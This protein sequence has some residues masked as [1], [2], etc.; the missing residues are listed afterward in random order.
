MENASKA[1]II[2]SEVLVGVLLLSLMATVFYTFTNYQAQ[3]EENYQ[4]KEINQFNI[5]F[6]V[7]ENKVLTP[8][9][10]VTIYNMV[11]D[12]NVKFNENNQN[13]KAIKLTIEG[14]NQFNLN[15]FLSSNIQ[16]TNTQKYIINSG[17][18]KTNEITGKVEK[19]VINKFN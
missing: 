16:N 8:Q 5:K 2:A 19:I 15:N 9:D 10:V 1:L 17:N 6:Y 14:Q 11:Q 18:I 7:Y 4:S 12:Y 3:I 13:E